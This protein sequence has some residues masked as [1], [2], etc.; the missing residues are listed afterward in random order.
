MVA[1]RKI[2]FNRAQHLCNKCRRM[3]T[4]AD[5]PVPCQARLWPVSAAPVV[6]TSTAGTRTA[7]CHRTS[8]ACPGQHVQCGEAGFYWKR[9]IH[10]RRHGRHRAAPSSQSTTGRCRAT[11]RCMAMV[12]RRRLSYI[13]RE[14]IARSDTVKGNGHEKMDWNDVVGRVPANV[15]NRHG[16]PCH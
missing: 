10:G 4:N 2:N 9:C 6:L 11:A 12:C 15:R 7:A 8:P 13:G 3:P 1:L 16:V 5:Q 14:A